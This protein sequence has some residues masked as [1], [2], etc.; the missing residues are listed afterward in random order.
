MPKLSIT[1]LLI[2]LG[3]ILPGLSRAQ[4]KV[5]LNEKNAT[6]EQVFSHIT[7]QT[8]YAFI[9][10]SKMIEGGKRLTINVKD[11][12]LATVLDLCFAAQPFSYTI[13]DKTIVIRKKEEE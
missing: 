8:G 1:Y 2:F 11:A 6:P 10:N 7:K 4:D 13:I 3:T 9:Y 5:T 12:S